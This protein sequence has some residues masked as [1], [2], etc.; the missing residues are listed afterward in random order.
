[1]L[2]GLWPESAEGRAPQH[3]AEAAFDAAQVTGELRGIMPS[4]RLIE[5]EWETHGAC[6]GMNQ[7]DYFRTA[8]RAFRM[9][10]I[11]PAF[12]PP[13]SRIETTPREVRRQF[14]KANPDF[15]AD[16]F[17]VKDDGRFLQEVRVCLTTG[18]KPRDCDRPGD[19]RDKTIIVRPIR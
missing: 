13:V 2:H 19:T 7:A 16:A 17:A 1:M 9:V 4:D 3:C 6:S 5:H 11:P 12:Q 10:K 14:A 18:L 8:A 15:P